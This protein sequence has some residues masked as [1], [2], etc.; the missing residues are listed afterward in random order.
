MLEIKDVFKRNTLSGY[1]KNHSI[2]ISKREQIYDY[3]YYFYNELR[4]I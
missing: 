1:E 4:S 3:Q 2:E